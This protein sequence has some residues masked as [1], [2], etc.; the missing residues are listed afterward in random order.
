MAA[1]PDRLSGGSYSTSHS[2]R[3]QKSHQKRL[4]LKSFTL[5]KGGADENPILQQRPAAPAG[6]PFPRR[7]STLFHLLQDLRSNRLGGSFVDINS[8]DSRGQRLI[9]CWVGGSLRQLC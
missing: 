6:P 1:G 7:D 8:G 5:V 9:V 3:Q 4:K 2:E